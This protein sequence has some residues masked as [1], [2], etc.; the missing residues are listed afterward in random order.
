MFRSYR[1]T[2]KKRTTSHCC[3]LKAVMCLTFKIGLLCRQHLGGVA[4]WSAISVQQ[5][6]A[7]NNGQL[8]WMQFWSQALKDLR[9]CNKVILSQSFHRKIEKPC[10]RWDAVEQTGHSCSFYMPKDPASSC[11]GLFHINDQLTGHYLW[12]DFISTRRSLRWSV[13]GAVM[14]II[15]DF[16]HRKLHPVYPTMAQIG[17][18]TLTLYINSRECVAF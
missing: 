17:N 11:L 16:E 1:R 6:A 15:Q 8:L 14:S 18:N 3:D 7:M 2:W 9:I 13:R 10:N 5:D 4:I 12:R